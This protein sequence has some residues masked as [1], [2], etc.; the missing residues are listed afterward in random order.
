MPRPELRWTLG[1][2]LLAACGSDSG[3][4]PSPDVVTDPVIDAGALP[5]TADRPVTDTPAVTDTVVDAPTDAVIDTVT[6]ATTDT[7]LDSGIDAGPDASIDPT[8]DSVMDT[9]SELPMD[10]YADTDTHA[11]QVEFLG[12]ERPAMVFP[13]EQY[14]PGV[15]MPLLFLLHGE[16]SPAMATIWWWGLDV[17]T[18]SQGVLLVV[19]QAAVDM[20]GMP[21][22]QGTSSNADPGESEVDDVAYLA[23]LIE[24]AK[25]HFPVDPTRIYMAG[26]S[27][28]GIMAHRMAC[29]RSDLI[30]GILSIGGPTWYDAT[31]CGEPSP[32][33]VLQAHGTWDLEVYYAGQPPQVGDPDA[34]PPD[35]NECIA[36][37]CEEEQTLCL[38]D[39]SCS[40]LAPCY[41]SCLETYP[42]DESME[43]IACN[44]TCW[45]VAT[46]LAQDLWMETFVCGLVAQCFSDPAES[47]QG[48][49][50]A[51]ETVARWA[52]INGC[53]DTTTEG[54]PKDLVHE[55]PGDD[56]IP[57]AYDGCTEGAAV[58]LWTIEKG[59]H[60]PG[61]KKGWT[62]AFLEW[63]LA[64]HKPAT[65]L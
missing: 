43:Q 16:T 19:P 11:P 29:E 45:A 58:E 35:A 61:L 54:A 37:M 33:A 44:N 22:W 7:A 41:Q 51:E 56:T 15:P 21:A 31:T 65:A 63:L 57:Q 42:E 4:V 49:A 9:A 14:D 55:L 28:G 1:L 24:E 32:V 10:A 64:Q 40:L 12:G 27:G 2:C 50:S 8:P 6:D 62:P 5:D 20:T 48:Y 17:V 39:L 52:E 18:M 59:S 23:D 34:D 60:S 13:P 3:T 30:A 26:I 25:G 46:S 47:W 53:A 36:E 38:Y